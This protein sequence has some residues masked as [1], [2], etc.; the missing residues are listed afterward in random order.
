[1]DDIARLPP[2]DLADLFRAAAATRGLP[3]AIV[4]KDF[5]VC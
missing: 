4:E 5:W 2:A 1:M 3:D